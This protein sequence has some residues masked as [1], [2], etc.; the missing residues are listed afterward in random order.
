[1]VFRL[2]PFL[3]LFAT[4]KGIATPTI[5]HEKRLNQ[6]P[7]VQPVPLMMAELSTNKMNYSVMRFLKLDHKVL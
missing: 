5:K 6:I 7:E 4:A 2:S 3:S 1:M